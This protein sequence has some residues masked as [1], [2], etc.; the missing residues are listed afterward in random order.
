[1]HLAL[2]AE[3]GGTWAAPLIRQIYFANPQTAPPSPPERDSA[4]RPLLLTRQ[5][6]CR[7]SES[8]S[9]PAP[10]NSSPQPPPKK[11]TPPDKG[12]RPLPPA[13]HL[14]NPGGF[15]NPASTPP[16]PCAA[17][18]AAAAA[19]AP[20]AAA[21]APTPPRADAAPTSSLKVTSS[22]SSVSSSSS[23]C[24]CLAALYALDLAMISSMTWGVEGPLV[25][26]SL[27][28]GSTG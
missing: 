15:S 16:L 23:F 3:A 24:F 28:Q 19:A 10:Q 9:S 11:I 7:F 5:T 18:A 13:P 12:Q 22:L 14:S 8:A 2:V 1:M 21:A 17:R 27:S 4:P 20:A 25:T 26:R 6:D